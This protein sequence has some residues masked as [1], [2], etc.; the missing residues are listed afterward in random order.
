MWQGKV[1]IELGL[2]VARSGADAALRMNYLTEPQNCGGDRNELLH[3]F[4]GI[5]YGIFSK[6]MTGSGQ[7]TELLTSPEPQPSTDF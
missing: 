1:P 7:V 6:R 4:W 5:S 2:T 3:S